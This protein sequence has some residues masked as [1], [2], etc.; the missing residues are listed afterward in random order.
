MKLPFSYFQGSDHSPQ[1]IRNFNAYY[2][3]YFTVLT[4]FV[5]GIVHD[6]LV[7]EDI[8]EETF[9]KLYRAQEKKKDAKHIKGFLFAT[10]W[11]AALDH[12]K[13]KR[14][15]ILPLDDAQLET[16]ADVEDVTG[17]IGS[18]NKFS[19]EKGL[20]RRLCGKL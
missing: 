8:V 13:K 16:I 9:I 15:A 1:K 2:D 11:H 6:Q 3:K 4:R 17:G 19:L 14:L 18:I 12:V 7:A 20:V 5:D 10:V